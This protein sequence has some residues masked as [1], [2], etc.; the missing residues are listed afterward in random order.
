MTD[1]DLQG[2]SKD[3]S[4]KFPQMSDEQAAELCKVLKGF[5]RMEVEPLI[6]SHYE[7][8]RFAPKPVDLLPKLRKKAEDKQAFRRFDKQENIDFL[9]HVRRQY[10]ELDDT[11]DIRTVLAHHVRMAARAIM[12]TTFD[13]EIDE[14]RRD[15]GRQVAARMLRGSVIQ[16]LDRHN[17][18][19]PKGTVAHN[20]EKW[21]AR[22]DGELAQV[23]IKLP[24][25]GA[26]LTLFNAET[27]EV[28]S[29]D[30]QRRRL[31]MVKD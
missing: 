14:T 27:G 30:E 17:R 8:S 13:P 4:V 22:I 20:V 28:M 6:Q 3:L 18:M 2:I 26:P 1:S 19:A 5:P 9:T 10:Q 24:A 7:N 25:V 21:I 31:A 11:A 12:D 16:E 15:L 23:G 29:P